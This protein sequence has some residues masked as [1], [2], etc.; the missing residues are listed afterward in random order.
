MYRDFNHNF[1]KKL[2]KK[3]SIA[4]VFQ[5]RLYV[6]GKAL[7]AM[8]A[9]EQAGHVQCLGACTCPAKTEKLLGGWEAGGKGRSYKL[10]PSEFYRSALILA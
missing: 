4:E 3:K 5:L 8:S 10:Y 9:K 7:A 6:G 1:L 2:K